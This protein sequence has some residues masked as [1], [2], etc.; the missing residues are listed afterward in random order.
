[1]C[2]YLFVYMYD[3]M[4]V[5]VRGWSSPFCLETGLS[6]VVCCLSGR[7][8]GSQLQ[9]VLLFLP[10]ILPREWRDY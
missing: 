8:S 6:F 10:L 1:M 4:P 5:G 7:L 2:V 9:W 3:D